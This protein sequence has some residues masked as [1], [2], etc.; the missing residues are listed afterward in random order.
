MINMLFMYDLPP[1]G[2]DLP[3]SA[4]PAATAISFARLAYSQFQA[5]RPNSSNHCQHIYL[6]PAT[7]GYHVV[8]AVSA[9]F[10]HEYRPAIRYVFLT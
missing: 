4:L 5:N 1:A 2:I 10:Y 6:Y 7:W 9:A 3:K 8:G